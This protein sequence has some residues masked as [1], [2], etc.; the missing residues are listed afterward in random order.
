MTTNNAAVNNGVATKSDLPRMTLGE[1]G[2]LGLKVDGGVVYEEYMK[3]LIWPNSIR[4]YK[5]MSL[6]PVIDSVM[7]VIRA[8]I[9]TVS[10]TVEPPKGATEEQKTRAKFIESC[11][12]VS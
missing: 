9:R 12:R 5:N 4:T 6:D 3:D 10:W 7:K 2:S 11:T 1:R 8:Y